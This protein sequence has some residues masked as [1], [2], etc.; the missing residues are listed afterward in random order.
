MGGG[1]D[2][3]LL[4][5]RVNPAD[6]I[7]YS[8]G[9]GGA[10]N[11]TTGSGV[12]GGDSTCSLT[13]V[14]SITAKA[15]KGAL[16]I[17]TGLGYVRLAPPQTVASSGGYIIKGSL[18]H[19]GGSSTNLGICKGGDSSRGNGGCD[20]YNT[21]GVSGFPVSGSG[22]G[23]GGYAVIGSS[24]LATAGAAG[25]VEFKYTKGVI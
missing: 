2:T 8:V 20:F 6:T 19:V 17:T 4:S 9:A 23:Y 13:G 15:G 11:V 21:I 1:A 22:Y 18:G 5:V 24:V 3:V 10:A 12:D 7:S 14:F 25:L 16:P